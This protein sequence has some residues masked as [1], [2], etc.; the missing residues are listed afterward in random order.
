[1]SDSYLKIRNLLKKF[2][3]ELRRE[4]INCGKSW[5]VTYGFVELHGKKVLIVNPNVTPKQLK[6]ILSQELC[7]TKL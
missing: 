7:E 1:M 5:S 6:L 4:K 3:I 2:N